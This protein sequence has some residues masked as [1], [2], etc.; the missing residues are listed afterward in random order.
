MTRYEVYYFPSTGLAEAARA[1]LEYAGAE[2]SDKHPKSWETEK[3]LTP[4][5]KLP[6]LIEHGDDGKVVEIFESGAIYR[7]L[8]RKFGLY[9]QDIHEDVQQD[10]ILSQLKEVQ[11]STFMTFQDDEYI[12]KYGAEKAKEASQH[13]LEK[14]GE[15]LKKNGTGHYVGNRTTLADICAYTCFKL[16]K[17]FGVVGE[18]IPHQ[19]VFDH[20][21]ATLASDSKFKR[22]LDRAEARFANYKF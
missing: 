17:K 7:Y 1:M 3:P 10:T 18:S 5:G 9:G 2:W 8:A 11:T 16:L 4:Y 12:K 14:H 6:V 15:L 20:F 13:L 22:Y 19:E 21:E